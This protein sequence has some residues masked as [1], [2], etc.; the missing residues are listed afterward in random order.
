MSIK[1]LRITVDGRVYE[2]DVEI[3][4]EGGTTLPRAANTGPARKTAA[5][6]SASEAPAAAAAPAKANAPAAG[7][8]GSI[9]SPLAAVV[10]SIDV[11]VGTAVQEGTQL[12]TL[13]AM[14]MNTLVTA[15][16]A[17]TVKTVHVAPG[18]A[19]EEGQ[20]LITLG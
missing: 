12:I 18:D 13:E 4:D 15:T 10:V 14:K 5:R 16:Q 3:T 20:L 17:G 1:H 19:V 6:S 2:V 11:P 7:G 9:V 8:A